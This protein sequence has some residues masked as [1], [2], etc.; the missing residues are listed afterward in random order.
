MPGADKPLPV[1]E[2]VNHHLYDDSWI[3]D[4]LAGRTMDQVGRTRYDGDLLSPDPQASI[5]RIAHAATEAARK[6][7][8]R[9]KPVHCSYGDAPTWNYFWQLNIARTLT[10]HDL[11][12]LIGKPS[13]LTEELAH[14]MHEGTAPNADMWRSFGIYRK[15][16]Q[17]SENAPWRD[18]Y[19]ALTGRRP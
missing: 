12:T 13:P 3:P 2:A 16:I 15:E 19:L 10:A 6:V 11:A 18:R 1:R 4:M 14:G 8:D 9:D 17:V 5:T 7:T